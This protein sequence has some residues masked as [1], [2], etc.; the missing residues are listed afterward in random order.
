MD[1]SIASFWDSFQSGMRYLPNT[2]KLTFIPVLVGLILGTAIA[3]VRLYKIPVVSN[4]FGLLISLYQGIPIVVA[5]MIYNLIFMTE[6]D[7]IAKFFHWRA[8]LADVDNIWIGIF[9]L[10]MSAICS[11]EESIKGAF[12]SVDKGQYEAGYSVGLTR[13][14][15][16]KRIV[17]PQ[18]IPV[19]IPM[20]TNNM[21]GIIKGSAVAMAIGIT[22]VL[23]GSVIPCSTTYRFLEGYVAAAFIYWGFTVIVER[24][25]KVIEK[26][27]DRYRRKLA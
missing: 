18:M 6:Y 26:R 21:I 19:A 8:K 23:G 2:W 4:L 14:Q 9:A 20:L 27:A 5:L 3:L 24:I 1:F 22:E 12:L 16:L 15:T 13:L 7:H 17:I 25:A 10:S 11:M